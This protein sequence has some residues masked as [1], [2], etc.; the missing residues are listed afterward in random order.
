[1]ALG[2]CHK[3]GERMAPLFVISYLAGAGGQGLLKT[4][5][6]RVDIGEFV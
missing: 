2:L 3:K 1:M 6:R 5:N 4:I